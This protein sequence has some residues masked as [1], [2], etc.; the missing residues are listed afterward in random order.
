MVAKLFAALNRVHNLF[1]DPE[2]L[3]PFF[4]WVSADKIKTILDKMTQRYRSVI[5]YP[6]CK[7]F[8]SQ[9]P[10]A[11]MPHLNKW[12]ATDAFFND[13]PAVDDGVPGH[14]SCAM[15]QILYGLMSGTVHGC[16]MKSEKQVGQAFEDH[17]CKVGTPIGLKSDNAMSEL[18]GRRIFY[19]STVLIMLSLS[20]TTNPRTKPNTRSKTSNML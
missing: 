6:F 2:K 10:G 16:P 17:V 12:M 8:K 20:P 4:G 9:Y 3:K 15:M 13:T 1:P 7:H 11:N 14:G 19:V 18:H 5:H